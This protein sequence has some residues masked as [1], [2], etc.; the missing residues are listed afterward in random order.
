ML[1]TL[2]SQKLRQRLLVLRKMSMMSK[3]GSAYGEQLR[4]YGQEGEAMAEHELRRRPWAKVYLEEAVLGTW[5][6]Q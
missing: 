3:V 6:M 2:S 5:I 1:P 4:A